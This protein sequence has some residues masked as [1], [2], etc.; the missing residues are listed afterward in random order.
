MEISASREFTSLFIRLDLV[1]L[2][3]FLTLLVWRRKFLPLIVG[4]VAGVVY[5]LVDYG[6]FYWL[7]GT[8]EVGGADPFGLL[9]WLSF[10]YGITN[11]A[12]I[13]L[14]LDRDPRATEWSLIII[15][16]WL[17]VAFLSQQYGDPGTLI[18]TY[19]GTGSYHGAMVLILAA[20]YIG[21][22]IHNLRR[23]DR[24]RIN[25]LVLMAIGVGVQLAWETVLLLA[26]IRPM[27][28]T[29]LVVKSLIETNLGMP[30][31]WLIHRGLARR[32]RSDLTAQ[33]S[34][35]DP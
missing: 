21:L 17:A 27:D 25:L 23:P 15:L 12:W 33:P 11:F 29:Q 34:P 24:Q 5:F 9:L 6:I 3:L 16:A 26:G 14:L 35:S 22:A 1:W 32:Y 18:S 31:A 13:W 28:M 4:L 19:R 8:R 10:S 20:G 7:L 30:Y 2:A